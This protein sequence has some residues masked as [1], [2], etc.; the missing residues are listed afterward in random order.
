MFKHVI[1]V[2]IS[3]PMEIEFMSRHLLIIYVL[4][5]EIGINN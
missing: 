2:L 4:P 1:T 5:F 3:R